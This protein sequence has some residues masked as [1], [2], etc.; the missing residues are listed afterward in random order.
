ME[1]R[2]IAGITQGDVNSV[3]YELIIKLLDENQM[4]EF[5]TP[6]LYGSSKVASYYRKM[7]NTENFNLNAIKEVAEANSKRNNIINCV[8]DNVKVD[9]GKETPDSSRASMDA[10]KYALDQLDKKL[11]HTLLISPQ[12]KGSLLSEG[13]ATLL[14]YLT[15]RYEMP[16]AMSLYVG[17]YMRVAFVSE[18]MKLSDALGQITPQNVT[19]K[20]KLLHDSLR[21]D[22]T[23]Q[24]PKIA[25]LGLNG[26]LQEEETKILVPVLENAR[27]SAIVAMG[28]FP[29]DRFFADQLYKKFD[30]V[31]AM[32][33]EQGL[34]PF[35]S[36]EAEPGAVY[37]MGLPVV[38]TF[39]LNDTE[40]EIAG[41]GEIDAQSFRNAFY[42]GMD[43]YMQRERN[44]QLLKNQLPHYDIVQ[45][46]N[47]SDLNVEQIEGVRSETEGVE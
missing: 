4:C 8:D 11:I 25:V 19:N 40:Y 13:S 18:Q 37:V 46:N 9:V 42:L 28:P 29:A 47:E 34:I 33:P 43:V 22:F 30:A 36:L 24:K 38:C 27:Q 15:K 39:A 16:D 1:N 3:A 7:L 12:G 21:L 5:C 14:E 2:L 6:V 44:T 10:L 41:K 17:G 32:Y 31:L 23:I 20:L 45:N 26:D 35:K